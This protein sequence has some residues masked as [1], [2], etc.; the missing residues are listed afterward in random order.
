MLSEQN[1][2]QLAYI[3]EEHRYVP[4]SQKTYASLKYELQQAG[5][6][7]E[8]VFCGENSEDS[9]RR[10]NHYMSRIVQSWQKMSGRGKI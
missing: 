7:P 4:M 1:R 6:M 2:R 8:Q 9:V 10:D 3:L 5:L